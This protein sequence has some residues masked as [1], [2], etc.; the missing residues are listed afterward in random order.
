[1]AAASDLI[2]VQADKKPITEGLRGSLPYK[3]SCTPAQTLYPVLFLAVLKPFGYD[4]EKLDNEKVHSL[5]NVMTMQCDM[6]YLFDP[7]VSVTGI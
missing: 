7:I 5:S 3:G 2:L 1:L 6:Y 4:A